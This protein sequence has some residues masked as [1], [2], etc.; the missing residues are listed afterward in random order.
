MKTPILSSKMGVF[1]FRQEWLKMQ[2]LKLGSDE[3]HIRD[4]QRVEFTKKNPI[5][6]Y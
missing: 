3:F 2:Y 5:L 1:C 4:S 6:L